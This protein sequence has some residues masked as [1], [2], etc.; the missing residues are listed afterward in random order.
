MFT[1]SLEV[2]Y[3]APLFAPLSLTLQA[4]RLTTLLGANGAGKSSLLRT[5]AGLQKPLA[6]SVWVGEQNI[7]QS[8]PIEVAKIISLVLTQRP[9]DSYLTVED[10]IA[11]GRFPYLRW[12]QRLQASDTQVIEKA[13]ELTHI[14]DLRSKRLSTLSDGQCQKVMIAR[15]LVQ[16]T[17]I[18]LL[19][20]PTAHLDLP[21]R[22][23]IFQLLQDLA[24]NARKSILVATHDLEPALQTAD[25]VWLL[26][27]NQ[28]YVEIPEVL[29]LRGLIAEA[30]AH[31]NLAYNAEIDKF[32][33]HY[34]PKGS[35]QLTGEGVIYTQT[36]KALERIG[37]QI[38]PE[39]TE[40][41]NILPAQWEWVGKQT[42]EH[43][44]DLIVF[45]QKNP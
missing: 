22:F 6:G 2:G 28:C 8:L 42:F 20:E 1:K 35:F 40:K 34:T 36:R 31:E 26:H 16:D 33:L 38:L 19:D 43:L 25:E 9:Q 11:L 17:P 4:R 3:N 39:A 15:A 44:T 29:A 30:F 45:L 23:M 21:S 24:K 27:K 7:H 13:L 41:I 18:I 32:Q 5:L 10:T 12:Y 37:Y 14:V